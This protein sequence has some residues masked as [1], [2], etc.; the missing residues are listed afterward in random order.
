MTRLYRNRWEA[1][2]HGCRQHT[3][4][5]RTTPAGTVVSGPPAGR[6]HMGRVRRAPHPRSAPR[7]YKKE[8]SVR[9][10]WRIPCFYT[11]K[12]HRR[13]GIARAAL[14]AI[15]L[16]QRAGGGSVEAMPEIT[17]DR[18]AQGRFLFQASVELFEDYGFERVR[19]LG[20]W[21]WLVR[22]TVLS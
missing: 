9:P 20:K 5:F 18:I 7:A 1:N 21:A 4:S 15:D 17:S 6:D 8:P 12:S 3:A 11:D 19:Q 13:E 10:A 16:I 22:R 14:G 2:R